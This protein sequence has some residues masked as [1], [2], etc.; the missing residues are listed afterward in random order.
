MKKK[1]KVNMPNKKRSYLISTLG[2]LNG[3][4]SKNS[5]NNL[6]KKLKNKV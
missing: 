2:E 4:W 6:R 3:N 1:K 5:Y